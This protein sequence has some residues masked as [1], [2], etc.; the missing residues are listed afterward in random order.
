MW[1]NRVIWSEGL[2][3]RPQHFQQQERSLHASIEQKTQ[4]LNVF[5]WGFTYI[6]LDESALSLGV[7]QI[8]KASG[9]LPDGTCFS[10]PDKDSAPQPFAV[11]SLLKEQTVFLA[12]PLERPGVP[13]V[14]LEVES[15]QSN[16]K[17]ARYQSL[18]AEV[19]DYCESIGEASEIQLARLRLCLVSQNELGGG[20]SA[21]GAFR[22][23]ERKVSGTVSLDT[24]FIPPS[25]CSNSNKILQGF[26][27]MLLGLLRQRAQAI[28]SRMSQPGKGGV[29]EIADFLLLQT[30]NRYCALFNHL[31]VLANFHPEQLYRILVELAGELSTFSPERFMVT[32]FTP[33]RHDD[34]RGSFAPVITNLRLYLSMV[35]EQTAIQIPI[36][37]RQHGVRTSQIADLELLKS[38]Q[39][40]LA[41]NAKLPAEVLRTR[42]PTQVKIGPATKLRDLVNLQLPGVSLRALP[43]VPRQIPFHAGFTY[44]ELDTKHDMWRSLQSSGD[45]SM[46][47]A[48]DFPDLELEFWAIRAT[49]RPG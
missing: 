32:E 41:V 42:F 18:T 23:I 49:G 40:V 43:A 25:L 45:F 14:S 4:Q 17:L 19:A 34:L 11:S 12:I 27:Q 10:I 30:V 8:N 5:P 29:S 15:N 28:A 33:Y 6:E 13:S 48:G 16:S 39:F 3:L 2:F 31:Q 26:L 47:V 35:L 38:A 1:H 7:V 36:E 21:A 46:H 24:G 20:F 22:V 37:N 9:I 44:F